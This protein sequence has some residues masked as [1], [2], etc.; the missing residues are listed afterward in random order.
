MSSSAQL[1]PE[2]PWPRTSCSAI[3]SGANSLSSLASSWMRLGHEPSMGCHRL[4]ETRRTSA[5]A[6]RE[7]SSSQKSSKDFATESSATVFCR[8]SSCLRSSRRSDATRERSAES[9]ASDTA[10]SRPVA[11]GAR[12]RRGG[13][14]ASAGKRRVLGKSS[15]RRTALRRRTRSWTRLATCASSARSAAAS[16]ACCARSTKT[17][18]G[19]GD[20]W[21]C[22]RGATWPPRIRKTAPTTNKASAL[23]ATQTSLA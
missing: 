3:T 1:L 9:A 6:G 12:S 17:L 7:V 14:G 8:L 13:V 16:W 2:A 22:I 23:D 18:S 4:S 21:G 20:L 10:A 11:A 15:A 19:A 5:S